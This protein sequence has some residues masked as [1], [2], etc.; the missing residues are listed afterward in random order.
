MPGC[1]AGGFLVQ[2]AL[3][4]REVG[5]LPAAGGAHGAAVEVDEPDGAGGVE[6]DV[7]GVEVA[8]VDALRAV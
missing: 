7:A 5:S 3:Q 1:G 6:Q 4:A 2:R 8:V